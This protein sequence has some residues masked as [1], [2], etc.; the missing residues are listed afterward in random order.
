MK[1]C[2]RIPLVLVLFLLTG[3]MT[4]DDFKKLS[5]EERIQIV[6]NSAS[7]ISNLKILLKQTNDRI[8][9][10]E[11]ILSQGYRVVEN[12]VTNQLPI[13]QVNC[14]T[15]IDGSS[16]C[17]PFVQ[18]RPYTTCTRNAV[19]ISFEREEAELK[20]AVEVRD[21]LTQQLDQALRDCANWVASV[22]PE[23]AFTARYK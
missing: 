13:T 11:T 15:N 20:K 9:Y 6:C 7:T 14:L 8:A 21:V 5:S 4:L 22:S 1:A 18:Y 12:C 2:L 17:F 23:E 19:S 10:Q 16:S 3:C